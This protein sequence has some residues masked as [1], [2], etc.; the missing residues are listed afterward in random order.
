MILF[1]LGVEQNMSSSFH[2]LKL[3]LYHV[4][5]SLLYLKSARF[6]IKYTF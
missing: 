2:F 5:Y 1:L 6:Y 4:I 3:I